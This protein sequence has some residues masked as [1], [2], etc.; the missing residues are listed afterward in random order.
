MGNTAPLPLPVLTNQNLMELF[1]NKGVMPPSVEYITRDD[2]LLI[3][4]WTPT[5]GAVTLHA[6][7][8]IL[9]P[10]GRIVPCGD[11]KTVTGTG[12]TPDTLTLSLPEGFLMSLNLWASLTARGALFAMAQLQRGAGSSDT[13]FPSTLCAG[14]V[15]MFRPVCYPNGPCEDSKDGQGLWRIVQ[16]TNP[17]AG[18]EFTIQVP[19]GVIWRFRSLCAQLHTSAA[20]GTRLP[21]L[22]IDN[23]A[24]TSRVIFRAH[25]QGGTGANVTQDYEWAPA[26]DTF[27]NLSAPWKN[28][29]PPDLA[30]PGG[31]R[32]TTSTASLDVADQW[33][34]IWFNVEQWIGF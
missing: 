1:A 2:I 18:A 28:T 19:T 17:A 31:A 3:T 4:A 20:A 22:F 14:Y 24:S 34:N 32:L 30:L 8:R 16:Q 6:D 23:G 13:C 27:N 7:A 26:L 10:D 21:Q 29:I 9:T 11:K 33:Q 15:T 25:D 5:G 12:T